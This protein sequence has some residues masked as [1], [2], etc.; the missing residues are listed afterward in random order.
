MAWLCPALNLHLVRFSFT[1]ARG[2]YLLSR[3]VWKPHPLPPPP[4]ELG[5]RDPRPPASPSL[6]LRGGTVWLVYR[7]TPGHQD[8]VQRT[9]DFTASHTAMNGYWSACHEGY[10]QKSFTVPLSHVLRSL[11]IQQHAGERRTGAVSL[12]CCDCL[13]GLY[14]SARRD[15]G[16]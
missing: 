13:E 2:C 3:S 8:G 5:V 9:F 10:R 6:A 7:R 11:R 4:H 1:T 12:R 14:C 16:L 15:R